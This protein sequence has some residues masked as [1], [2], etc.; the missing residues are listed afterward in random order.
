MSS[1]GTSNKRKALLVDDVSGPLS[2]GEVFGNH[3]RRDNVATVSQGREGAGVVDHW[4]VVACKPP[5][6]LLVFINKCM[7]LRSLINRWEFNDIKHLGNI[8]LF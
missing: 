7:C 6:S 2:L 5:D 3:G 8:Q 4:E 1:N